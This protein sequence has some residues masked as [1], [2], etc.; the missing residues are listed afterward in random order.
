PAHGSARLFEIHAHDQKERV[1]YFS[2]QRLEA[3]GILMGGL[4]IVDRA[5]TNDH[6]QSMVLAIE[7]VADDFTTMRDSL[8]G[9]RR[10]GNLALELLGGDQ[11]FIGG[12]VQVIYR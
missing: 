2:G 5:G 11:G 10:E 1:G 12:D 9:R 7:D 8:Q 6:E 3:L 4:D